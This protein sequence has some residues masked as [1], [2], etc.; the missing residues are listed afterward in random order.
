MKPNFISRADIKFLI[1]ITG[2]VI[3]IVIWGMRLEGRVNAM[4][5]R[6]QMNKAQFFEMSEIVKE[7]HDAVIEI[8]VNQRY[9]MNELGIET[10]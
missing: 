8:R 5:S 1:T 2:I 3:A 10:E 7:T 4:V 9:I 6:E